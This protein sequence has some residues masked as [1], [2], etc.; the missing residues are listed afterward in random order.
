VA[1]T[2]VQRSSKKTVVLAVACIAAALGA[3]MVLGGILFQAV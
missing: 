2:P 3:G 1:A